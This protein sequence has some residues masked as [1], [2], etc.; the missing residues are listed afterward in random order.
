MIILMMILDLL[1]I[2]VIGSWTKS[3]IAMN[4]NLN[5]DPKRTGLA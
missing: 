2:A 4:P 3:Q 5:L 1:I